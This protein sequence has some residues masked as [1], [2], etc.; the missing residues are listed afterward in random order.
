MSSSAASRVGT[1]GFTSVSLGRCMK[2]A[3]VLGRDAQDAE[4][5]VLDI[6]TDGT[7]RSLRSLL[8]RIDDPA[9]HVE[10]VTVQT[11]DLD[12]VFFA[13]TGASQPAVEVSA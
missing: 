1:S 9:L 4:A 13:L 10:T 11:P 8:D 3:R 5:L 6:P 7:L 12:D 2:P